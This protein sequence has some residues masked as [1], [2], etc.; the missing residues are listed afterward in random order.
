MKKLIKVTSVLG[1]VVM[2]VS[3]TGV[4]VANAAPITDNT[5]DTTATVNLEKDPNAKVELTKA[6]VL[7]FGTNTLNGSAL[8]LKASS[9]DDPITVVD[10]G[11]GQGWNVQVSGTTFDDK[12]QSLSLKGAVLTLNGTV[13]SEDAANQSGAPTTQSVAINTDAQPI[14]TATTGNG[15]G[16]WNNKFNAGDETAK[17]AIPD[18]NVAGTYVSTLTWTL[19]DAPSA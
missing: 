10:A 13:G 19:T 8:N 6:P 1:A 3:A 9:V 2:G 17:L 15:V 16:T 7:D 14:F 12:A 5:G 4:G 11:V 18:G